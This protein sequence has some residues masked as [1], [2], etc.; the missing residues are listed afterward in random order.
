M[1]NSLIQMVLCVEIPLYK[2]RIDVARCP[3]DITKAL[4]KF[5]PQLYFF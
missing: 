5:F 3:V 4:L 2:F 1:N